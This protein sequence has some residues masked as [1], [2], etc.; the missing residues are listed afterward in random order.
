MRLQLKNHD[1]LKTLCINIKHQKRAIIY[2]AIVY[3]SLSC[4]TRTPIFLYSPICCGTHYFATNHAY[5]SLKALLDNK[6][7][8]SNINKYIRFNNTEIYFEKDKKWYD[9]IYSTKITKQTKTNMNFSYWWTNNILQNYKLSSDNKLIINNIMY[10]R[11]NKFRINALCI[12]FVSLYSYCVSP[13]YVYTLP[14]IIPV[15]FLIL[16]IITPHTDK[17]LNNIPNPL[18]K[19]YFYV[20]TFGDIVYTNWKYNI[21]LY[22]TQKL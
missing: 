5:N 6:I 21:F 2:G 22:P 16:Y 11:K 7:I 9:Y 3:P 14:I 18:N 10:E 17:Y 19:K 15:Y 4:I 13:I 1:H 8:E 20:S 12:G